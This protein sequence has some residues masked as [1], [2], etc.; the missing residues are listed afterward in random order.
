[1]A[2]MGSEE[3]NKLFVGNI[4]PYL[5]KIRTIIEMY[6]W[7]PPGKIIDVTFGQNWKFAFITFFDSEA[8]DNVFTLREK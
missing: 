8:R 5:D 2:Q 7:A 1:M 4:N 3:P 6:L